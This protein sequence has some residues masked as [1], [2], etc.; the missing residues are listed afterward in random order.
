MC[1]V[2]A[3][4]FRAAASPVVSA[5]QLATCWHRVA[6]LQTVSALAK[7]YRRHAS[8]NCVAIG[9]S[10]L[11]RATRRTSRDWCVST[12]RQT[13]ETT[14]ATG[15]DAL[16]NNRLARAM[17]LSSL[18]RC[19]SLSSFS[20]SSFDSRLVDRH[21]KSTTSQSSFNACSSAPDNTFF[22]LSTEIKYKPIRHK[23]NTTQT[24]PNDTTVKF[25][26]SK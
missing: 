18:S 24:Y 10:P 2:G 9:S 17:S 26:N 19:R 22:S 6:R 3:R 14:L 5:I 13:A 11:P 25:N 16:S 8:N 20:L 15:T 23:H 1:G 7:Q 21:L 4:M 12:I